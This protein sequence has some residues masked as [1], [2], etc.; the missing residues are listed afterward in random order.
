MRD[1]ELTFLAGRHPWNTLPDDVLDALR[2]ELAR[3]T[4]EKGQTIYT[5]GA[6][7]DGLYFILSGGVEVT[8]PAGSQVS[9]LH[10]GNSFGERGLLR[11]GLA[12]TTAA[13]IETTNLICLP[14]A[15]FENL[16]A[17]QPAFRAF[18]DRS[19][20]APDSGLQPPGLAQVRV[21]TLMIRD[22]VTCTADT[23][24]RAAAELMRDRRISCLC[25]LGDGRLTG[26]LTLR[27]LVNR[28]LA[29][30]LSDDTH[31]GGVMTKAPRTLPPSAIGSDVLHMMV[32]HRLGHLPV[33]DGDRL[34][35]IVTQTDLT[36]FQ[37][38]TSA[39]LVGDAARATTVDA[40]SQV[41]ARIPALLVHLI[42]TGQRHDTVTRLITDVGDVVTRRLLTL[43]EEKLGPAP[44]GWLWLAC[45]S[46][47]RREQTGVSD[48]DNCLIIEDVP[49]IADHPWFRDFAA[50][51]CDGLNACGYV[52]C[53]GDMMATN[54]RWR[55]PLAVWREYFRGWIAQ[56]GKE[57][58][59]LASVMF[60]LRPVGGNAALFEGLQKEVLKAASGN[61]I[62]T[63]HM[64]GNALTHATPLGLL[65]GLAVISSGE[66]RKTIDTKHN[67]VVPVVD[68][69]RMYALQGQ[70]A[71]VNTRARLKA[72]L[73]AGIVSARG[74]R[75]LIDAYDLIAQMRLEHQAKQI[76]DGHAPDNYLPPASLSDF[77]RSHLRD[78]FVV[79]KTMQ[80]A[81]MQGR[82]LLG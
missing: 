73:A 33:V 52:Y 55:Q 62:F 2:P 25:V 9:V 60:D 34:A 26:I 77:E 1:D 72:A 79:V 61:S 7:L 29:T 14:A 63:A 42:A 82:G 70:I 53:P 57:A 54:P 51:V 12:A 6:P 15:R 18:F 81:L 56:P 3:L 43:G 71:E 20:A 8:D 30:G 75:D 31:V 40:L 4:A 66:H 47:G 27:D 67:G 16:R 38:T 44:A 32:E 69:G 68:L 28:A 41:T 19:R 76:R 39:G 36:R 10:A 58:Q 48:Q 22:P 78:A 11:D 49:G 17:S 65:R 59:M 74:G 35:G 23:T 45:G 37:A 50:F 21:G 5:A 24:I 13:A 46:Q 64:A 80:A